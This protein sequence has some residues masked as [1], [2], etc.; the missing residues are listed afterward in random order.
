MYLVI[1][2]FIKTIHKYKN[3]PQ[4][5]SPGIARANGS[6]RLRPISGNSRSKF[7]TKDFRFRLLMQTNFHFYIVDTYVW[8]LKYTIK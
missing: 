5:E 3:I 8:I 1:S 4:A 7:E 6:Q 2:Y